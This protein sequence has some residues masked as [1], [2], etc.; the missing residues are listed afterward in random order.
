MRLV[1]EVLNLFSSCEE[2]MEIEVYERLLSPV[3][4]YVPT[5]MVIESR[6][7]AVQ[8]CCGISSKAQEPEDCS[9]EA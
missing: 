7:L 8:R 1:E 3:K 4:V 6:Q 9:H 5:K 2:Q